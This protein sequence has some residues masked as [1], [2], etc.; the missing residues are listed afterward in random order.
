MKIATDTAK[1][2]AYLKNI[3]EDNLTAKDNEISLLKC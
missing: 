2:N 1:C 3:I